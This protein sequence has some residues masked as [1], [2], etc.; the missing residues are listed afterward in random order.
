M[1]FPTRS[2][3]LQSEAERQK[4]HEAL[5]ELSLELGFRRVTLRQLIDRAGVGR[6]TFKRHFADLDD[7]FAV[8][9]RDAYDAFLAEVEI[10]PADDWRGRLRTVTYALVRFWRFDEARARMLLVE[11]LSAEPLGRLV[12]DQ[13]VETTVDLIDQGRLLMDDSALLS[14]VTAEAMAG[15]LF[16]QMHLALEGGKLDEDLARELMYCVVLPYM[17]PAAAAEELSIPTPPGR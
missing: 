15:A 14:R 4:I 6:S 1:S 12:R 8:Y 11:A 16:N 2:P 13:V 9:I 5:V 7:C 10:D 3:R 17:G